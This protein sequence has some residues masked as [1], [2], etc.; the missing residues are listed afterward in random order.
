MKFTKPR[1]YMCPECGHQHYMNFW[2][3][4]CAPHM[5]DIWRWVKCPMCGRRNWVKKIKE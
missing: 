3:W 1:K 4:L 5:F 2:K